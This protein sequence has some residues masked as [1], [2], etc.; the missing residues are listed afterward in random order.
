MCKFVM[1]AYRT[2]NYSIY[3][4][5]YTLVL[6]VVIKEF[7]L[8]Y[9]KEMYSLTDSLNYNASLVLCHASTEFLPK[10]FLIGIQLSIPIVVVRSKS[11]C[12]TSYIPHA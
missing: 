3:V 5:N 4:T 1:S 9:I 7:T 6:I 12:I 8:I 11:T 2:T 10:V